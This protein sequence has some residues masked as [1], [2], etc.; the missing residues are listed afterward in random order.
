MSA[1][2][3]GTR[4]PLASLMAAVCISA[5]FGGPA[6]DA[7]AGNNHLE[8]VVHL[9]RFQTGRDPGARYPAAI[10]L[11]APLGEQQLEC[12]SPND[13]YTIRLDGYGQF[14]QRPFHARDDKRS[15]FHR[16]LKDAP[17][18]PVNII[19]RYG[20]CRCVSRASDLTCMNAGGHGWSLPRYFGLPRT[21]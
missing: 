10:C 1:R 9:L 15:H 4:W 16:V 5:A 6:A 21:W 13:G 7:V 3:R 17:Y 19:E 20:S 8:R 18:L 11:I 12:W 14:A 2:N